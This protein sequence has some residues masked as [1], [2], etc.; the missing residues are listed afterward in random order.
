[1]TLY[2]DPD[3]PR[4]RPS[5][6][7]DLVKLPTKATNQPLENQSTA[8][9]AWL[10]DR[11][12]VFAREFVALF[13]GA[14]PLPDGTIGARGWVPLRMPNRRPL[15]AREQSR[16]FRATFAEVCSPCVPRRGSIAQ[17]SRGPK[18]RSCEAFCDRGDRI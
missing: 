9:L 2:Q 14:E 8:T 13:M 15:L 1:M 11:S 4:H 16:R 10:I 6:I 17:V 3:G 18:P 12:S 7:E 5:L